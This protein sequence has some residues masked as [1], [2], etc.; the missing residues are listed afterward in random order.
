MQVLTHNESQ[1][2]EE[3]CSSLRLRGAL[4]VVILCFITT[5]PHILRLII[6]SGYL[7][8]PSAAKKSIC[9]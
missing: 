8:T 5:K 7:Q 2:S 4:R 9:N 1:G 3:N 6:Q